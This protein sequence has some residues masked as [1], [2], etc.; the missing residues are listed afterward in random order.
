MNAMPG[1]VSTGR[2]SS[3]FFWAMRLMP[4]ARREAMF[5]IY[6]VARALDD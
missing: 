4:R 3:T 1:R 2:S 6:D 5:A